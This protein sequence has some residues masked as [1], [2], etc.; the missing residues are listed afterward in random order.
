MQSDVFDKQCQKTV[1]RA[2]QWVL[3]C[4]WLL[5]IIQ[6]LFDPLFPLA[7]LSG[8]KYILARQI[9]HFSPQNAPPCLT[10]L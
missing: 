8:L 7:Y 6:W 9:L 3:D 4:D 5:V 1:A 10:K 2:L